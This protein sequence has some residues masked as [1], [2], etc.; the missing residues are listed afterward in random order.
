MKF[1]NRSTVLSSVALA[2]AALSAG[3]ALA[4]DPA[5][6]KTRDQ[7]RADFLNAQRNGDLLADGE[8]GLTQRQVNPQAY[9]A[10]VAQT[11]TR[12]QVQAELLAANRRS[13][14]TRYRSRCEPN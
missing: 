13:A 4:A 9:P 12:A 10:V 7:V 14:S 2:I 3:Q 11:R 6:A 8:S 5:E 1:A